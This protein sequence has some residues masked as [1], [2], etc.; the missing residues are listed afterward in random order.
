MVFKNRKPR[1][2]NRKLGFCYLK[3]RFDSIKELPI[4]NKLFNVCNFNNLKLEV[5]NG[6][7]CEIE[8]TNINFIEPHRFI[9]KVNNISLVLLCYDNLHFCLYDKSFPI[10][11]SM[12][13]KLIN[14]QII[15]MYK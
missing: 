9:V 2:S 15:I 8:S 6:L 4:Y 7:I 10:N 11:M 3:E 12:L 5:K 13:R 1:N 14:K